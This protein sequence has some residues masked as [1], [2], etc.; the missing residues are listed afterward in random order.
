MTKDYSII[1]GAYAL[2]LDRDMRNMTSLSDA[3]LCACYCV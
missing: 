1:S 2:D 3:A